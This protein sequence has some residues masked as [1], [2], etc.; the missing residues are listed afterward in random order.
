MFV[1]A[2][3]AIVGGIDRIRGNK[4]GYGAKF[5]EGFLFLGPIALSIAG[6]WQKCLGERWF[7]FTGQ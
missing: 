7:P 5:E 6:C 3:G 2:A 4:H 1:M